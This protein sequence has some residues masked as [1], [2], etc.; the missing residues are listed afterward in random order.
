MN[1]RLKPLTVFLLAYF[2]LRFFS[3]YFNP[4]TPLFDGTIIN[5]LISLAVLA[6]AVYWLIKNDMRGWLVVA[7]EIILGGSGNI[8][9]IGSLSLRTALLAASLLIYFIMKIRE[10]KAGQLFTAKFPNIFIFLLIAWAFVSALIGFFRGYSAEVSFLFSSN[11]ARVISDFIPYLFLLYYFPLVD[12]LKN[13]SFKQSTV[14]MIAAAVIGNAAITIFTLFAYSSGF[15][16]L[17]DGYYHWFRDVNGGKITAI[18]FGTYAY[19]RT[20]LNEHLLLVPVILFFLRREMLR[21]KFVNRILLLLGAAILSVNLTRIY[22]LALIA[23]LILMFSRKHAARWIIYSSVLAL[24]IYAC[25]TAFNLIASRGTSPGWEYFGY[26]ASSIASPYIEESSQTRMLLL[27][28]IIKKIR[29][30]PVFG[31]GLGDTV[32][33]YNPAAQKY[34][35]TPHFDWGY[36]EIIDETGL[37]GAALWLALIACLFCRILK[38]P[39]ADRP[40]NL[41]ILGALLIMN[42]TSPALFHVFGFIAIAAVIASV[43]AS[44]ESAGGPRG[45]AGPLLSQTADDKKTWAATG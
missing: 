32:T 14:S 26:R 22:F 29:Q 11:L 6:L 20:V 18:Y 1:I 36:L 13:D 34:F 4:P 19:F 23:G 41:S 30:A 33:A 25:F 43:R 39:G 24:Y 17:Q 5:S 7:G 16:A 28:E 8:L 42:I 9:S 31:H 27:P 37:A 44:E 35:T 21:P 45:S 10:R 2:G 40:A 3:Y 12:L 15:F 38:M